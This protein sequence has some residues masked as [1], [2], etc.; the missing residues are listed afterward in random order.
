MSSN[1]LY[2]CHLAWRIKEAARTLRK[3]DLALPE[4]HATSVK[5]ALKTGVRQ[6]L[7]GCEFYN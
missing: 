5:S 4:N 1:N 3:Q 7:T 6:V 2:L